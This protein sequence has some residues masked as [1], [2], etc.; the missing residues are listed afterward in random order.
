MEFK[1]KILVLEDDVDTA[2]LLK[3]YL[4]ECDFD[5][6]IFDTVTSALSNIKY[7]KYS[8][9]LLD[10]NIPDFNGFEVLKFLNKNKIH[11]PVIV[12]SAYSDRNTK[13]QAFKLGAS[14]YMVKPID[15]EELEARIWVH[16]R[17]SSSFVDSNKSKFEIF[18]NTIYFDNVP[19]KL[20]KIEFEILK[21][22]IKH[23]NKTVKRELLCDCLSSD[24]KN[25]RSLDYH[26]KNIRDKINDNGTIQ[27]HLVTE[28]AL[29]Y[30][31][32]F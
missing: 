13:L 5:V 31:L 26:I 6:D 17:S 25:Q 4:Q 24:S 23:K 32:V 7:S 11:I 9:V 3:D 14:D 8:I 12:V 28:Y 22:L 21:I 15:T 29:G 2:L 18:E 20:T 10:L 27:K 16:I 19:L 30:K 1:N